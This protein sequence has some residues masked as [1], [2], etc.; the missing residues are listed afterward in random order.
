MDWSW[1]Q[2]YF[3][4]E[5]LRL[6]TLTDSV[7]LLSSYASEH[8]C[9]WRFVYNYVRCI[10]FKS[11]FI[12]FNKF[13]TPAE[14]GLFS[15]LS[16]PQYIISLSEILGGAGSF[17]SL[18]HWA[19]TYNYTLRLAG[20]CQSDCKAYVHGG[21]IKQWSYSSLDSVYNISI[22]NHILHCMWVA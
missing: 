3:A 2:R 11:W 8:V 14:L 18:P 15:F 4:H 19:P 10:T 1:H 16:L 13:E 17:S 5:I 12:I 7:Q 20:P 22:V 6:W 9:L 21:E